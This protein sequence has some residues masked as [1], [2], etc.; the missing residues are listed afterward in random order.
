MTSLLPHFQLT[1][2]SN[3]RENS[4]ITIETTRMTNDDIS[5]QMSRKLNEIKKSLNVQIQDA[6]SSAITEK[7]LPSIQNTF[8]MQGGVNCTMVDRGSIGLQ[9]SAKPANFTTGDRSSSGL[10]RD[11]EVENSQKLWENRP[12]KCFIHENSRQKSRQ[13]SVDTVNSEQNRD[14]FFA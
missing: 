13:C 6:I 14:N 9:D 7:I 12:R 1:I 5:N 11:S 2:Y 4:E 10:Q 8:E 3:S